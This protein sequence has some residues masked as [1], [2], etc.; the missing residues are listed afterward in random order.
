[1]TTTTG[2]ILLQVA[3]PNAA[4]TQATVG[5]GKQWLVTSVTLC[6]TSAS[7][8]TANLNFVPSAGAAGVANAILS[9]APFQANETKILSWDKAITLSAGFMVNA[10]AGTA[11]VI[12]ITISG[13]EVA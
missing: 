1:M 10:F 9:G 8:T 13:A 4:A 12:G 3:L 2:K 5:A 7:A 6:N 11:G